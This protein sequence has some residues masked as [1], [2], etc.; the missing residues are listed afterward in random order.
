MYR[1]NAGKLAYIHEMC[2][3]FNA[4]CLQ[5]HLLTSDYFGLLQPIPHK[6]IFL[7]EAKRR[8]GRGRPSSGTAILVDDHL[9]CNFYE[10]CDYYLAVKFPG[11]SGFFLIVLREQHFGFVVFFLLFFFP[12]TPISAY[13]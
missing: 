7:H 5:E 8:Y 13:C 6:T 11:P 4:M 3:N 2:S 9:D 12:S 1:H 10:S